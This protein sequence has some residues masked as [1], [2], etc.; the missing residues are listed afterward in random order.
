MQQTG[1]RIPVG[2]G[3]SRTVLVRP[4]DRGIVSLAILSVYGNI[5]ESV[6]LDADLQGVLVAAL[7][8]A[9]ED[10]DHSL[11]DRLKAEQ[12]AAEARRRAASGPRL[13]GAEGAIA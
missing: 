12:T 9:R 11:L 4:T 13:V 6:D 2:E 7:W 10:A 1:Y 3:R 5:L 8:L